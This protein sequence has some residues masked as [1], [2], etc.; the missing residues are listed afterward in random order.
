MPPKHR[1]SAGMWWVL[2]GSLNYLDS[3]VCS[4]I[5]TGALY[6]DPSLLLFWGCSTSNPSQVCL[7]FSLLWTKL[8]FQAQSVHPSLPRVNG[9]FQC[10]GSFFLHSPE[11]CA[12]PGPP[13]CPPGKAMLLLGACSNHNIFVEFMPS[14]PC[15]LNSLPQPPV[16]GVEIILL[17]YLV[18][19]IN[20]VEH[21]DSDKQARKA[22]R[23]WK[24]LSSEQCLGSQQ[25]IRLR[26][27]LKNEATPK[28]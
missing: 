10:S 14:F 23:K 17:P 11:T 13:L 1:S 28:Y 8:S 7:D 22:Q 25:E 6:L 20:V 18:S 9:N 5:S 16:C 24:I 26:H 21:S 4:F 3:D 19:L 2:I 27:T 15:N 12:C